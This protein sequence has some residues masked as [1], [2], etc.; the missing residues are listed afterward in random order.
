MQTVTQLKLNQTHSNEALGKMQ[1]LT[2]ALNANIDK[3]NA[4]AGRS[5]GWKEDEVKK[6]RSASVTAIGDQLKTVQQ[7]AAV[8]VVGQEFWQSRAFVLSQQR[9]DADPVA[10]ATIKHSKLEE[11]KLMPLSL[12]QMAMNDA[13]ESRNFPMA[14]CA[15]LVGT[16][17]SSN[18]GLEGAA[19][20]AIGD[21]E[22]PDRT[23][24]L[25]AIEVC[26]TNK[27]TGEHLWTVALGSRMQPVDRMNLGR[28]QQQAARMVQAAAA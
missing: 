12:L 22:I 11:M 4:D 18:A 17:A 13:K 2:D 26:K 3:I 8:A 19:D 10:D 5:Q 16:G 24:A 23:A 25:A 9:F 28:Q 14:Y 6:I 1:K 20:F 27:A 21:V 15:W 7:L